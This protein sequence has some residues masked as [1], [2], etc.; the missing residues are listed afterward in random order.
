[1]SEDLKLK[2]SEA[3]KK[4]S[5]L[6][7]G[8]E[9]EV[10]LSDEEIKEEEIFAL[11]TDIVKD[12]K[13]AKI[14][15]SIPSGSALS[16]INILTMGEIKEKVE[17]E[18]ISSL[19]DIMLQITQ[20][21]VEELYQGAEIEKFELKKINNSEEFQNIISEISEIKD[22]VY[23]LNFDHEKSISLRITLGEEET[24]ESQIVEVKEETI[25]KEEK[26]ELKNLEMIL[27]IEV[28]VYVRVGTAK[29]LLEDVLKLGIG[30]VI[31]LDKNIDEPVDLIVNDKVIARGEIVVIDSNFALRIT[32]IE[33]KAERIKK[34]G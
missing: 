15:V 11:I 28:P 3:L 6:I 33:T 21:I 23:N 9:I 10:N 17:E 5:D 8:K 19:Q 24:Q 12:S 27:D 14:I 18:D 34:L 22:T 32:E 16:L 20:N 1:M 4:S 7:F 2:I 26:E 30:S 25:E 13:K 29:M 31:E